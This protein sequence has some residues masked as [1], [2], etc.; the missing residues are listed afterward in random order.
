VPP[1]KPIIATAVAFAGQLIWLAIVRGDACS[2]IEDSVAIPYAL[3]AI[4]A[5][6]ETYAAAASGRDW[7]ERVIVG[8]ISGLLS[9]VILFGSAVWV[10]LAASDGSRCV[11]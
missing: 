6:G 5:L 8:L 9:A 11:T 7:P 2:A 1:S 4:G 3:T 10:I